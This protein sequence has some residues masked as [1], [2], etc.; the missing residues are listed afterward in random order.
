MG[1]VVETGLTPAMA[2]S[3]CRSEPRSGPYAKYCA[4][5][6]KRRRRKPAKHRW[7]K[8]LDDLLR[9]R[10]DGSV[11]N[12]LR[13]LAAEIGFPPWTVARRARLLGL[14][15]PMPDRRPWT[16]SED[17]EVERWS[18]KRGPEWIAS[19][20]GRTP[21]AV[22]SRMKRLKIRLGKPPIGTKSTGQRNSSWAPGAN[23]GSAPSAP[24]CL[25]SGGSRK[26]RPS[27]DPEGSV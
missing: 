4:E 9:R 27:T 5:C 14:A 12:R 21:S 24:P 11:R 8:D 10:Y 7:T 2:C 19:R 17:C 20:I 3:Q 6:A 25:S 1:G 15:R 13:E 22:V 26:E 16:E 18:G 23:G